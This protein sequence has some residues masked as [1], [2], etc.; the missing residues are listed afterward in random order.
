MLTCPM[1][2]KGISD[3][4]R[5]C[6]RCRTDLSLLTDYVTD[7]DHG[8]ARAERLTRQGEL[9]DAVW[10]YLEVLEVDPDNPTARRRP[11]VNS[12]ARSRAGAGWSDSAGRP[13][14]AGGCNRGR[15]AGARWA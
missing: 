1:C 11:F 12:T 6:P 7:L 13:G 10:A 8:L 4:V 15:S 5:T 9:A 14:S 3:P 2:K